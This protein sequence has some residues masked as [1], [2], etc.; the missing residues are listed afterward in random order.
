[1]FA[2][3]TALAAGVTPAQLRSAELSQPFRGTNVLGTA[4]TLQERGSACALRMSGPWAFCGVTAAQLHGMPLPPGF[5]APHRPLDVAVLAPRSAPRAEGILGHKIKA[6]S[7]L[8]VLSGRLPLAHAADAWCQLAAV[9]PREDLVAAGDFLL[10]GDVWAGARRRP[11]CDRQ[12]LEQAAARYAGKRGARNLR[13]ALERLRPDVDSRP[14]SLLRLLL[15]AAGVPEP[16]V[17]LAVAVADGAIELHPDL[18]LPDWGVVFEYQGD[19]HRDRD[20]YLGDI[21]RNELL[22]AAGW[23]VIEVTSKDLFVDPDAFLARV[24]AVLRRR[25]LRLK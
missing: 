17:H 2:T 20:R 15:V 12:E 6:H 22:R 21:N 23:E 1:M 9:L 10:A 3:S 5:T 11:L 13:W 25:G 18:A 4:K 24:S 16:V 8:V 14:E 7:F 19:G